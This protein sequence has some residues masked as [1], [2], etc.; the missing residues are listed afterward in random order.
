MPESSYIFFSILLGGADALDEQPELNNQITSIVQDII[1]LVSKR[2]KLTPK[3]IGFGLTLHQAT[4]S[5]K[6]VDLFHATGYTVEMDTI[7]RID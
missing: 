5:E 1:F 6:L 7:R 2:R 3:H 4:R